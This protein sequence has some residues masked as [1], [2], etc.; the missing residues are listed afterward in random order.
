[1]IL[2]IVESPTKAKKIQSFLKNNDIKVIASCGHICDL[3]NKSLSIDVSNNFKPTFVNNITKVKELKKHA[4]NAD[5][6]WIG[7]DNDIEGEAIAWHIAKVLNVERKHK[8]IIFNEITKKSILK[9]IENPIKINNKLV[10]AQLTRRI[11]D[12]LVGYKVSP[13]LW[14]TIN[15]NSLSAGRVQSAALYLICKKEESIISSSSK[16]YC[17]WT[18]NAGFK[19]KNDMFE[20]KLHDDKKQIVKYENI[21]SVESYLQ[22]F[23]CKIK[24]V[25]V[26]TC[27]IKDKP[28]KPFNTCSL[29][30]EASEKLK[31]SSQQTMKYAQCLYEHG[32]ITYMRTD[33]YNICDE[34]QKELQKYIESNYGENLYTRREDKCDTTN[35]HEAIRPT[36]VNITDLA[37]EG[38]TKAHHNL[39]KLIWKRTVASQMIDATFE[40][41]KYEIYIDIDNNDSNIFIGKTKFLIDEG[42]LQVYGMKKELSVKID[43]TSLTFHGKIIAKNEWKEPI[44]HYTESSFIKNLEKVGIGRPSTYASIMEKLYTKSYVIKKDIIGV[45]RNS[46]DIIY[47]VS[48]KKIIKKEKEQNIGAEK[49]KLVPTDIGIQVN[50]F[51][52]D[53][54]SYIVDTN[55]TSELEKKLDH[56]TDG[57]ITKDNILEDF[58]VKLSTHLKPWDR[59]E[60]N[61]NIKEYKYGPVI[62][63]ND[64][65]V[66]L[67]PIINELNITKDQISQSHL[68]IV[69]KYPI[70]RKNNVYMC[71][72]PYGVYL[73]KSNKNIKIP[74]SIY[75][76][77]GIMNIHK[78]SDDEISNV[79][80]LYFL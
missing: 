34:A 16:D 47:D 5:E 49:M 60:I 73:K 68:D 70:K 54:F 50:S 9:A 18:I 31:L 65:F 79:V 39:Y 35:A 59:L 38:M 23:N 2:L 6:I 80:D 58:W 74:K 63:N 29:Q 55:F 17:F 53:N 45:K 52:V 51:L 56:I 72:G 36:D 12:R 28:P 14:S 37:F 4:K 40:E 66:S 46:T 41:S 42:W 22:S 33:N 10:D 8:R 57:S 30:Q 44:K 76:N 67:N 15:K 77:Y 21:E 25:Q 1:M 11:V 43:T 75:S 62:K 13:I 78:M 20:A 19:S 7:S 3:D 71:Y 32:Y 61:N 69:Q 27:I 26:S 48:S 24:N 64:K